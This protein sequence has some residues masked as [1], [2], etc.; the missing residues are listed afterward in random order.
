MEE[1]IWMLCRQRWQDTGV[2][3]EAIVMGMEIYRAFKKEI[4]RSSNSNTSFFNTNQAN[5]RIS[6]RG[7]NIFSTHDLDDDQVKVY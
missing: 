7:L 6:W 5:G 1:H 3:P 4:M 2:N